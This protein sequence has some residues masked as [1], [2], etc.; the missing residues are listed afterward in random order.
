MSPGSSSHSMAGLTPLQIS[1]VP[2]HCGTKR[3]P[4]A[5]SAGFAEL[6]H[7]NTVAGAYE[8]PY[9]SKSF[10]LFL[11]NFQPILVWLVGWGV[12]CLLLG[13]FSINLL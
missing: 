12:F 5:N 3:A 4:S 2:C 9:F 10:A 11:P 1:L 7:C 13:L 6:R 8:A